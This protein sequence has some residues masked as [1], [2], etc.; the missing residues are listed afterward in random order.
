M[1]KLITLVAVILMITGI[2][3]AVAETASKEFIEE[4]M[5]N[6]SGELECESLGVVNINGMTQKEF[7]QW[8]FGLFPDMT[9]EECRGR[10]YV[11]LQSEY[12]GYEIWGL[13]LHDA[14]RWG[15]ELKYIVAF[16]R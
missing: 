10:V 4:Y 13:Y 5:F 11:G 1:K 9:E 14:Y 16:E 6:R 2:I 7:N 12:K 15:Y 3:P 8:C